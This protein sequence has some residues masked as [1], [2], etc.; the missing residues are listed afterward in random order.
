VVHDRLR[1]KDSAAIKHTIRAAES[2]GWS[3]SAVIARSFGR[4]RQSGVVNPGRVW[5]E[6]QVTTLADLSVDRQQPFERTATT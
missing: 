2:S 6:P 1:R 3:I 4:W 5:L